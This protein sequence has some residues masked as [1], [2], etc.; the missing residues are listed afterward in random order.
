MFG[1]I[2]FVVS[3]IGRLV[4]S[5]LRRKGKDK[6]ADIVDD[7]TDVVEQVGPVVGGS[8]QGEGK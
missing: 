4:S 3:L 7:V 6:P 5:L 2:L 8:K 1:K